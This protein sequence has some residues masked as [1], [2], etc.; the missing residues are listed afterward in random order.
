MQIE[1][2]KTILMVITDY[3]YVLREFFAKPYIGSIL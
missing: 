2:G 1:I 3:D